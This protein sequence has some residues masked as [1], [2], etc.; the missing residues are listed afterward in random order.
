M[1]HAFLD[2]YGDGDSVLHRR[3][4]R[5]KTVGV[6]LALLLVVS[7]PS[8]V[9][10]PFAA[11]LLLTG[12]LLTLGR[13][14]ALFVLKRCLLAAPIILTAALFLVLD[15]GVRWEGGLGAGLSMSLKAFTAVSLVTL[16]TATER[17]HRILAG[18]RSLGMPEMLTTLAAFMYRYA[19][20][21]SDEVLRTSRAR[22]SRTPGPLRTGRVDTYGNQ[23]GMVFLRG[24]RR[25]R[26]VY[27]AMRS[28]GFSGALPGAPVLRAGWGDLLFLLLVAGSFGLVRGLWP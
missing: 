6:L 14:P 10:A 9:A 3:D 23:A 26:R 22:V 8:G 12:A 2:R 28:R 20:I 13:V 7:E 19:F 5:V 21:L 24:W 4:P 27:Q 18:L 1:R 17:F 16:L 25:S 15:G 11:Y